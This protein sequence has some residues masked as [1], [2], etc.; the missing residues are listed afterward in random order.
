MFYP[1]TDRDALRRRFE[2]RRR[3]RQMRDDEAATVADTIR[4]VNAIMRE[5][6]HPAPPQ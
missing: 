3:I 5:V 4:S 1:S 2:W 6:L